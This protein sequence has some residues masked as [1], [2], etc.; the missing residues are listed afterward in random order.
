MIDLDAVPPSAGYRPGET[1]REAVSLVAGTCY[2]PFCDRPARGCDYDHLQEWPRGPTS[3]DNG[4]PGD[5]HHHRVKTHGARWQVSQ[6]YPGIYLWK[7]PTGCLYAVT[8]QGTTPVPSTA[9]LRSA[10]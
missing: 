10:L 5:R 2:F 9:P 8:P 3:L 1:L 6:P 7:S 4:G